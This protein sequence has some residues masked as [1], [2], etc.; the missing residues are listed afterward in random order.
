MRKINRRSF[1]KAT[2][3]LAAASA[4]AACGGVQLHRRFHRLHR[5]FYR[6]FRCR[7]GWCQGLQ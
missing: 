1:L 4:L 2:G 5:W 7:C 6:R 3:I